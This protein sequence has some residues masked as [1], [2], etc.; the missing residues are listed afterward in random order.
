MC[1]RRTRAAKQTPPKTGM[2]GGEMRALRTRN[3]ATRRRRSLRT[4]ARR[5]PGQGRAR[6]R[7]GIQKVQPQASAISAPG[8]RTGLWPSGMTEGEIRALRTRA[9]RQT[10]PKTG[11]TGGEMCAPRTRN[12]ATRRRR[13]LRT[14]ARRHPG[15]G[16]VRPRAGIQKVQPQA[17]AISAPGSRTGLWP[18]GMT[19][20]EMRALRTRSAK[21]TPPKTGM[22]GGE[23]RALRVRNTATGKDGGD[24]KAE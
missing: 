23:M 21:Q 20:G 16:R 14:Q 9:A 19:G 17:S 6:P 3:A 2:A 15:Q 11:M 13:S 24:L 1:A 18:S 12:A 8:S 10:P 4:Q 7:A 5:H 22:M